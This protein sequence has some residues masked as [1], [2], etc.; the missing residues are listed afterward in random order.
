VGV[1]APC[2]PRARSGEFPTI[3]RVDDLDRLTIAKAPLLRWVGGRV[4]ATR[5]GYGRGV[6]MLRMMVRVPSAFSDDRFMVEVLS[7]V[8]SPEA[9]YL[10]EP[11]HV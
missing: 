1:H 7:L 11:S 8:M 3:P 9:D 5:E 4:H 6:V 2:T 10:K